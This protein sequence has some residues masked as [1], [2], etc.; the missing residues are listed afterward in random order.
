MENN[1]KRKMRVNKKRVFTVIG[2]FLLLVFIV[3]VGIS[4]S[5]KENSEKFYL[6]TETVKMEELSSTIFTS[7][8]V[9]SN[10]KRNLSFDMEGKV[11]N[12]Y[13]NEG[14]FVKKGEIIAE[15]DTESVLKQ[16]RSAKL[17]VSINQKNIEKLRMSGV[18]NY[19]SQYKNAKIDYDNTK[20]IYEDNLQLFND[21]VI[22][23]SQLNEYKNSFNISENEYLSIKK[24]YEGYG[25]GIDLEILKLQ[26]EDS[27]ML[28][29]DLKNDMENTELIASMEGTITEKLFEIGDYITEN[30][31]IIR[32]ET[33]DSL[34]VKTN[35]SQ[36]DI[37]DIK[38]GQKVIISRNGDNEE[39]EGKVTK[40]ASIASDSSQSSVVP[41][42]V[43]I[44]TDNFYKPNYS[45]DVEI[46]TQSSKEAKVVP[47][48]ALYKDEND[49]DCIFILKNGKSKKIYIQKGIN[50]ALLI[51]VI[52][53]ELNIGDSV[54][55]N[56]P[57][58]FKEGS[59]V[60]SLNDDK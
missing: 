8:K 22:S 10:E 21:G 18:I 31:K 60:E 29:S 40:I 46:T 16:I 44:I 38:K 9:E 54:I 28:L 5:K 14:D 51:E 58:E 7:G 42:E 35:I 11:N 13:F 26:L 6:K 15:L 4:G 47:Y 23:E 37:N 17:N 34:I 27:K 12:I 19:E 57:V 55:L 53:N 39:F 36:Y 52:A 25:N 59:I 32:I 56:P 41:V 20:K 49:K 2:I 50:G 45:V 43:E 3:Y 1:K 30:Q 24:K 48:E 33:I